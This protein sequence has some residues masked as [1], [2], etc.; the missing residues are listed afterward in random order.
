MGSNLRQTEPSLG[1]MEYGLASYPFKVGD[2][3]RIPVGLRCAIL[4]ITTAEA[5][6][7]GTAMNINTDT[8]APV[9][10]LDTDAPATEEQVMEELLEELLKGG[11]EADAGSDD[12][13]DEDGDLDEDGTDS[14]D[15]DE[16]FSEDGQGGGASDELLEEIFEGDQGAPADNETSA[17]V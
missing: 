6:M 11:P 7:E 14:G 15:E 4:R 13:L 12:S 3:V 17:Q 2:R 16:D 9:T 5:P 1:P 10:T 8:T